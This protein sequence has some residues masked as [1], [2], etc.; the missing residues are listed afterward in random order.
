MEIVLLK[1]SICLLAFIAFYKVFLERTSNHQFKR[2]YLLGVV[3]VSITIPFITFVE[4]IEPQNALT[5]ISEVTGFSESQNPILKE[6]TNYLPIVLWSIYGLGVLLFLIRFV[7]NLSQ[8]AL[9]IRRNPKQKTNNFTR[10]LLK[11]LIIPHTFFSYIFFNKTKFENNEIPKE[12]LL[13]EQTHAKQKHSLDILFIE[14]LQILFWFHPLVYLIKKDIKLN[15]E[16]LA[17]Q[18]VINKGIES[19]NYQKILLSFSSNQQTLTLE[20]AIN[21]S[22]IKKRFT[23]MKTQTSKQTFWLRS[24][25]LLPLLAILIF[26]FSTKKQIEKEA[27]T[28]SQI[29]NEAINN[30]ENLEIRITKDLKISVNDRVTSIENLQNML[31]EFHNHLTF[32]EKQNLVLVEIKLEDNIEMGFFTDVKEQLRASGYLK[33]NITPRHPTTQKQDKATPKQLAEYNKLAKK[34]NNQ[35]EG[36]RFIERKDVE[37]LEYIYSLMT[38]KQ[39]T[40]AEPFPNF[41]SPP[42][43]RKVKKGEVS[44]IPPPPPPIPGDATE[45]ERAEY[46]KIYE[47]YNRKYEIKNG[48]VSERMV[49][50]PPP[51]PPPIPGNATEEERAEYE[52]IHEEYNQKYEVKNG[53]VSESMIPPPPP[54]KSPLDHA[55]E[56]AKKDANF[57]FEGKKIT[58][59]EAIAILKKDTDL[60]ISTQTKGLQ[61]PMVNITT[62]PVITD[63]NGKVI[64]KIETLQDVKSNPKKDRNGYVDIHGTTYF[65]TVKNEKTT[66]FNRYGKKVNEKGELIN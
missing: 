7:Y 60:S 66:Y 14:V 12:V 57:Y 24:L 52:R 36:K 37:K 15:H 32:N 58:S 20:H 63:A 3:L 22:S 21:Y 26:S 27:E 25:L 11:D 33:L 61:K 13:H 8:I 49:S 45:E 28:K 53:H 38:E 6:P 48:H 17:D 62:Q 40:E 54:P 1:S 23:V 51:P 64:T 56:M 19:T 65:Y 9:K 4:Y 50:P 55:I 31:N 5:N 46:E 30:S 42:P 59:D 44:N 41:P 10:V 16:F 18:A 29:S 34:Y 2:I 47:E 35:P 39:K 43:V